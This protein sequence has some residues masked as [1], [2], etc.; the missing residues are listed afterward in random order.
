MT[1]DYVNT[2]LDLDCALDNTGRSVIGNLLDTTV[3]DKKLK[4]NIKDIK[5]DASNIIKKVNTKTFEYK[6]KKYG[7]GQ[8]FG[9]VAND[10]LDVLPDEFN[11]I[12]GQ[13]KEGNYNINHLKL[14]V[15][16]WKA[17]QE[18]MLKMKRK[19]KRLSIWKQQFMRF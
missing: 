17:L 9:F 7:K 4:K 19:T 12:I 5:V 15:I 1:Y 18:V 6:D 13:D 2:S 11:K 16:L 8:Q 10:L 3:S 14:S